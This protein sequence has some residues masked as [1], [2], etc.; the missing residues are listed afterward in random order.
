MGIAGQA[1]AFLTLNAITVELGGKRLFQNLSLSVR[2]GSCTL[3]R[4]GNGVGKTTLLRVMAGLHTHY[5]GTRTVASGVSVGVASSALS[6]MYEDLSLKENVEMICAQSFQARIL[7]SKLAERPLKVL[8]SGERALA[9]FERLI[10]LAPHVAL[11][12]EVTAHLDHDK[13]EA[14]LQIVTERV[15]SG[16][17]VVL[18]SHE[19]FPA[20]FFTTVYA[21]TPT[22]LVPQNGAP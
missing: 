8:S 6:L 13:R 4:G 11:L 19:D 12:D 5:S 14:L 7:P 10:A 2:A 16:S 17:S 18:V 21:L 9:G 22:G 1:D 20:D 3:I 15:R